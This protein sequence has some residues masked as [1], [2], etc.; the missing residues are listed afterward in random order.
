MENTIGFNDGNVSNV[1]C[2]ILEIFRKDRAEKAAGGIFSVKPKKRDKRTAVFRGRGR[3]LYFTKEDDIRM[4]IKLLL[5]KEPSLKSLKWHDPFAADG[6]WARVAREFGIDCF[7][8]DIKPLDGSVIQMDAFDVMPQPDTLYIGNPPFSKA[9]GLV[10]HFKYRCAFIM[11]SSAFALGPR[12][13]W[14]FGSNKALCFITGGGGNEIKVMCFFSYFDGDRNNIVI[15]KP[16]H[17]VPRPHLAVSQFGWAVPL[18]DNYH[19]VIVDGR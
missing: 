15:Q 5:E 12:H 4:C 3:E 10:G 13:L 16:A 11:Q 14:Y 19:E 18:G 17:L 1:L 6:R 9:R 2:G 7:S 8:S